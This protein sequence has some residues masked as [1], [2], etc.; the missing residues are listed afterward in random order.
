MKNSRKLLL[1]FIALEC[2]LLGACD[3][4]KGAPDIYPSETSSAVESV[5]ISQP[6]CTTL[7]TCQDELQKVSPENVKPAEP[8]KREIAIIGN[9]IAG[10]AAALNLQQA[11]I[12]VYGS[13]S[14]WEKLNVL[15]EVWQTSL[16][17]PFNRAGLNAPE[18]FDKGHKTNSRIKQEAVIVA[19]IEGLVRAKA[20]YRD[21]SVTVMSGTKGWLITDTEGYTEVIT[22][23]LII[24][25]GVLRPIRITDVISNANTSE[26]RRQLSNDNRIKTGDECLSEVSFGKNQTIGIVGAGGSSADCIINIIKSDVCTVKT[27]RVVVW[28]GMPTGPIVNSQAYQNFSKKYDACICRVR[29]RLQK[30]EYSTQDNTIT[31]NENLNPPCIDNEGHLTKDKAP[32][33]DIL[34]E[35]LGRYKDAPPPTVQSAALGRPITYRP[36]T[37]DTGELVAIKVEFVGEPKSSA[38]MYLVGA[39]ATWV[40]PDV[41]ISSADLL[42][43]KSAIDKTISTVN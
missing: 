17:E 14:F 24:G 8:S 31:V 21:T 43:F 38:A 1:V 26:V 30:V 23:T 10:T 6:A 4:K 39:A 20:A 18:L 28:G 27:K 5:K 33:I 35:S 36:V 32:K 15:P 25:T 9:G 40:P 29:D 12:R 7:Q 42:R 3:C 41:K 16:K 22:G 34:V 2:A 37:K 11:S 19:H 13:K